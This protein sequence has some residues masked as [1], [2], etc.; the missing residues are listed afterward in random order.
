[1]NNKKK[2]NRLFYIIAI[3]LTVFA[4]SLAIAIVQRMDDAAVAVLAGAVC[5]VG[6]SI[7][8]SL[9]VVWA[10]HLRDRNRRQPPPY[11]TGVSIPPIILQ[12]PPPLA[13]PRGAWP[14]TTTVEH[15]PVREFQVVGDE[16]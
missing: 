7:P 13:D 3:T 9:L 10:T 16:E 1:M 12:T 5:G 6:A 11:P 4:I 14:P 2:G 15:V 8:T